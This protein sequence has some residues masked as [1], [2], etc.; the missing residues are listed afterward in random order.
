MEEAARTVLHYLLGNPV[1]YLIIAFIAGFAASKN[2]LTKAKRDSFST[3][4]WEC[5]VYSWVSS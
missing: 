2:A 4:W 5:S 3:C 1:L